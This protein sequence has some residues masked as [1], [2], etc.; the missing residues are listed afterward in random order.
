MSS[1]SRYDR[2]W[3]GPM[4]VGLAVITIP[5]QAIRRDIGIHIHDN[6]WKI[7]LNLLTIR[8]WTLLAGASQAPTDRTAT[9]QGISVDRL[10]SRRESRSGGFHQ[11]LD[12]DGGAT[13][14]SMLAQGQRCRT[15]TFWANCVRATALAGTVQHEI[16]PV[17]LSIPDPPPHDSHKNSS[18]QR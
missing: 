2:R 16:I 7:P 12:G 17:G 1:K 18:H 6:L 3:I 4:G 9:V 13:I 15:E 14:D 10:C 11:R 5:I 8:A